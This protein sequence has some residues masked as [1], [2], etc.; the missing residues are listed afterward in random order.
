MYTEEHLLEFYAEAYCNETGTELTDELDRI[1][2]THYDVEYY[3]ITDEIT[4]TLYNFD[5]NDSFPE[6]MTVKLV[7]NEMSG[8]RIVFGV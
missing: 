1:E 7:N 6:P 3:S 2:F 4:I 5:D 8:W